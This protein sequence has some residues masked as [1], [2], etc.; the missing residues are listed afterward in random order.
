MK[1]GIEEVRVECYAGY[2]GDETPRAVV[3]EGERL[4]IVKVL[5]RK[6]VLDRDTGQVR[7]TWRCRLENGR[8]VA[9]ERLEGGIWRISPAA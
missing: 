5:S 1:P 3:L 7:D 8:T 2:K 4:E 6:K 9:I